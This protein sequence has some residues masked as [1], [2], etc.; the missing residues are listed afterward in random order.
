MQKIK[1]DDRVIVITGKDKGKTG[2]V[3]RLLGDDRLLTSNQ[4]HIRHSSVQQLSIRNRFTHTH[5]EGDLG[6]ARD[7]HH[8][9]QA[10]LFFQ[11]G[12]DLF[13]IYFL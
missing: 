9:I 5:I 11:P 8:V 3:T 1:K 12:P 2:T 10:E 6:D 4:L 13:V 7:F